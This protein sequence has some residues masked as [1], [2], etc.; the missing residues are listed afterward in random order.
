MEDRPDLRVDLSAIMIRLDAELFGPDSPH[1]LVE[2]GYAMMQIPPLARA[3]FWD[4]RKGLDY[5]QIAFRHGI[6]ARRAERD[7]ATALFFLVRALR[8]IGVE[9]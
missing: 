3:I 5:R 7:F 2:V 4:V 1:T 8:L 9:I 6:T